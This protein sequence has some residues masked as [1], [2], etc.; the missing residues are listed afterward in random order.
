MPQKSKI[1][2]N[3]V[4]EGFWASVC[5]DIFSMPPVEWRGESFDAMLV[6]VDRATNWI[7]AKPTLQEGLT[8]EKAA[9]LL[10]DGG[11]GEVAV[12]YVIT[13]D[14][15]SQFTS[16]FFRTICARL[17]IR[18]AFS[19]A[20]RPQ[21]NGRAE[22]AGRTLLTSLRKV[23][24]DHEVPWVESL[25]RILRL[26]HDLPDPET[27]L[28]PY[29]LVFGRERPLGGLPRSLPR[30]HPSA[31][32]FLD[33]VEIIDQFAL[34]VL[35]E[36]LQKAEEVVNRNRPTRDVFKV[37]QW[38]WLHRPTAFVGPKL[39]TSWLGPYKIVARVGEHSFKIQTAPRQ[40]YEVHNDQLKL[41]HTHPATESSYPLVYRRG[42]PVSSSIENL[43]KRVVDTK[44]TTEGLEFLVE[45][46]EGG[47][48]MQSWVPAQTLG[49]IWSQAFEILKAKGTS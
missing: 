8:G 35:R 36:E 12:P 16:Q 27:G 33:G 48:G 37:G 41:C 18:Q 20:H 14:Q 39:Q 34:K 49:P 3:P 15:G 43:I 4:V 10:L 26:R 44:H 9:N 31:E 38:V 47:G 7:L 30:A 11:W 13:S 42:D 24:A 45:W 23:Q 5:V 21:A 25:P 40:E 46:S 29:Q 17:G 2:M 28:S 32:E 6:C 19:Q 22:V 1:R